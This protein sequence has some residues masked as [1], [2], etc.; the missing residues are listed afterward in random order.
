MKFQDEFRDRD[1]VQGLV[2]VINQEAAT[3]QEPVRFMEVCGTHTMAIAKNGLREVMP[4]P[5]PVAAKVADGCDGLDS[6]VRQQREHILPLPGLIEQVGLL[7]GVLLR[8]LNL[9][10]LLCPGHTE[11]QGGDRLAHLEVQRAVLDLQHNVMVK[12]AVQRSVVFIGGP[13]P[14]RYV[15]PPVLP[16][17]VDKAAPEQ[18][19]PVWSKRL[20]QH[21]GALRVGP[22]IGERPRAMLGIRLDQEP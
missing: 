22:F 8:Q 12:L 17:V 18:C 9:Q 21:V 10:C 19:S 13:G 11:E 6:L 14:V 15:V 3:L 1:L 16:A 20:R 7:A 2:A 5:V 4:A